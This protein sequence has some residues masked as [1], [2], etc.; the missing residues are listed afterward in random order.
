[1]GRGSQQI[2]AAIHDLLRRLVRERLARKP[3]GHLVEARLDEIELRLAVALRGAESASERFAE[4]VV[5]QIDLVLD[6]AVAHAAAFRPG[7]AY[8]WRVEANAADGRSWTS[9]RTRFDVR[10]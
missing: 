4:Q 8:S 7:H 5:D 2:G 10:K 3:G 1:M 6:D 9:Q